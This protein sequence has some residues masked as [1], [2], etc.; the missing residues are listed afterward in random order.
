MYTKKIISTALV[1]LLKKHKF[2]SITVQMILE[3]AYVSRST[4]YKHFRD[5]YDLMI[6]YYT[7]HVDFL[8]SQYTK[9]HFKDLLIDEFTFIKDNQSYFSS[10]KNVEGVNSFW[11]FLY[12]YSKTFYTSN[13]LQQTGYKKLTA[14]EY[15]KLSFICAGINEMIQVWL[16]NNCQEPIDKFA[17]WVI[18]IL[19]E[20]LRQYL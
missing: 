8:V 20:N 18:D 3:E 6:W 5:K 9:G 4:F 15:L 1:Q 14:E 7:N 17:E 11:S 12:E 10:I 13:Y 2:E 19:P 16:T